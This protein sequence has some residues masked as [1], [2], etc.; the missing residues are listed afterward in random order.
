MKFEQLCEARACEQTSGNC[1]L[2]HSHSS[3][4]CTAQVTASTR[5]V[6]RRWRHGR[7]QFV[8]PVFRRSALFLEG[9]DDR[10]VGSTPGSEKKGRHACQRAITAPRRGSSRPSAANAKYRKWLTSGIQLIFTVWQRYDPARLALEPIYGTSQKTIGSERVP[11]QVTACCDR[12]V[13][14][15][16]N[17][18]A[19]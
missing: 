15:L 14:V 1:G 18:I 8:I 10:L 7:F 17:E 9:R 3:V 6:G 12:A 13:T 2:T 19:C 4:V 16:Y 5:T 11:Q